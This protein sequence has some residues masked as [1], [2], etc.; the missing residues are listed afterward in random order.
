MLENLESLSLRW[1]SWRTPPTCLQGDNVPTEQRSKGFPQSHS[2]PSP[3]SSSYLVLLSKL[4]KLWGLAAR[5][6]EG[7]GQGAHAPS[8]APLH[9]RSER[10]CPCLMAHSDLVFPT[11]GLTISVN[12]TLE[13]QL[14]G[15]CHRAAREEV[16][17]GGGGGGHC[18]CREGGGRRR[19]G[20][21]NPCLA[22]EEAGHGLA[23]LPSHTAAITS[24]FPFRLPLPQGQLLPVPMLLHPVRGPG[25]SWNLWWKEQE[26]LR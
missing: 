8:L 26:A 14:W 11:L 5:R 22:K 2:L 20:G 12:L 19:A 24:Q 4:V 16:G 13:S 1:F 6:Q 15:P 25:W 9:A 17:G 23:S 21:R 3:L 7:Q 18:A 10:L